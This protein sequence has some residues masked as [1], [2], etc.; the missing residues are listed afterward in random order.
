MATRTNARQEN[1]T[2]LQALG[3]ELITF[4]GTSCAIVPPKEYSPIE[5]GTIFKIPTDFR[6]FSCPITSLQGKITLKVVSEEGYEINPK[7]FVRGG[8]DENG[9]YHKPS[10]TAVEAVFNSGKIDFDEAFK[11]IVNKKI[12]CTSKEEVTTSYG[13]V[14]VWGFD[15]K[16]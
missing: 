12:I 6:I 10:G 7:W 4:K 13:K 9:Q 11:A 15:F 16:R 2:R 8:K 14:L 5:V 3:K 1:E